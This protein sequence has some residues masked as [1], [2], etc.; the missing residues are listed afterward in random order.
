MHSCTR[1]FG[2]IR[3]ANSWIFW[4]HVWR[5]RLEPNLGH[6]VS[7]RAPHC[8]HNQGRHWQAFKNGSYISRWWKQTFLMQTASRKTLSTL[9]W[10]SMSPT[11]YLASLLWAMPMTASFGGILGYC[12]GILCGDIVGYWGKNY[13][14]I[15]LF[16]FSRNERHIVFPKMLAQ[17][18]RDFSNT[19]TMYNKVHQL[20]PTMSNAVIFARITQIHVL[21]KVTFVHRT[22]TR[23]EQ[24]GVIFPLWSS[25]RTPMS[26]LWRWLTQTHS[27][28]HTCIFDPVCVLVFV[29]L[30]S[31]ALFVIFT[32]S[33]LICWRT[34]IST[35]WRWLTHTPVSLTLSHRVCSSCLLYPLCHFHLINH[36]LAEGHQ[37]QSFQS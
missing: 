13:S 5:N 25:R 3:M 29:L 14:I 19:N 26:T 9:F 12:V 7:T 22:Q 30:A 32:C 20:L 6:S 35:L 23:L 27:N 36:D 4:N 2:V 16:L 34:P 10:T 18:C 37:C 33:P 21:T 1:T 31:F 8:S 24:R 15:W 28:T 17:N 11:H